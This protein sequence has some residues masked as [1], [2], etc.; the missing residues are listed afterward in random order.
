[1]NK[2]L[3][4]TLADMLESNVLNFTNETAYVEGNRQLT[5]LQ[6]LERA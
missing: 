3:P 5:R 2:Y 6:V 1:M 4:L